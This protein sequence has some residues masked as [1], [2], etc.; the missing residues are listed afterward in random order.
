MHIWPTLPH[1][2]SHHTA[3]FLHHLNP[4]N[5]KVSFQALPLP[6]IGIGQTKTILTFNRVFAKNDKAS[7]FDNALANHSKK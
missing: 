1:F 6:T 3:I 7:E 5:E 4:T 2:P